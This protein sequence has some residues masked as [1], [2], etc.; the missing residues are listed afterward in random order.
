MKLDADHE[1]SPQAI[2]AL[3]D[4]LQEQDP[5]RED[6][7]DEQLR[8]FVLGNISPEERHLV[9]RA[10]IDSSDL[11]HRVVAMQREIQTQPAESL[12][13]A[14]GA[15]A[16]WDEWEA[17]PSWTRLEERSI[18]ATIRQ[19]LE[20]IGQSLRVLLE[21]P[22]YATVRRGAGASALFADLDDDGT[23]FVEAEI[24]PAA[25][26]QSVGLDLIDPA[27]G[28]LRID[29]TQVQNGAAR[30]TLAGFGKLT[31]LEAGSLP[32]NV[33]R[34]AWGGEKADPT[35]GQFLLAATSGEPAVLTVPSAPVWESGFLTV[36]LGIPAATRSR[37]AETSLEL[38]VQAGD[39]PVVLATVPVAQFEAGDQTFRLEV[40]GSGARRAVCG[41]LLH[42]RF[43]PA[44][45]ASV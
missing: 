38:S 24:D 21:T 45:T 20:A 32:G 25:E 39:A 1:L 35:P 14:L 31:G 11:R 16:R 41:S 12:A 10:L 2:A 22:R 28:A 15:D 44:G 5:P 30:F 3:R 26:G 33:F 27:G 8:A 29:Q 18:A 7:S 4:L 17:E 42:A 13:Q 23:L 6:P 40:A 9:I 19:T 43:V 37:F 36:T 34:L